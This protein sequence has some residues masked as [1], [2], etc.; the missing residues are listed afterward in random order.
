MNESK[1]GWVDKFDS[2]IPTESELFKNGVS[3]GMTWR[4]R[5]GMW[6]WS[7]D[8]RGDKEQVFGQG[9]TREKTKDAIEKEVGK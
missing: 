8:E 1:N 4:T 2:G 7:V 6:L 3:V 5:S 9:E